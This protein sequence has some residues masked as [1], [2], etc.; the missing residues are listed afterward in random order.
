MRMGGSRQSWDFEE[1]QRQSKELLGLFIER[2]E[3]E[4]TAGEATKM[5]PFSNGL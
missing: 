5:W 3:G 2:M 1:K 4:K